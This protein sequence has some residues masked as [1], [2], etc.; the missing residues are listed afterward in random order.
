[1]KVLRATG[2]VQ[3]VDAEHSRTRRRNAPAGCPP[4]ATPTRH[5]VPGRLTRS[6]FG[7][8]SAAVVRAIVESG[9]PN[10]GTDIF[11]RGKDQLSCASMV[12]DAQGWQEI[13]AAIA[14]AVERSRGRSRQEHAAPERQ[15]GG[16]HQRDD[17]RRELR[18]PTHGRV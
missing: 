18:V 6:G 9:M 13:S 5:M 7:H 2:C 1:M 11:G 17:R 15:R 14:R 3:Q 12:V 8:P 16:G 4:E 10:L